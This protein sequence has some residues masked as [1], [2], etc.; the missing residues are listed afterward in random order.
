MET[1]FLVL[2]A[3]NVELLRPLLPDEVQCE[4]E[5]GATSRELL[6]LAHRV[7]RPAPWAHVVLSMGTNDVGTLLPHET[8]IC[9]ATC[10]QLF[11]EADGV[12]P[13]V[14]LITTPDCDA[15]NRSLRLTYGED[16][17]E[18]PVAEVEADAVHLTAGGAIT[19]AERVLARLYP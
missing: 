3:S 2:G 12:P 15:L 8:D 18:F 17:I 1:K 10:V 6:A 9:I 16:V 7:R 14:H 13:R 5:P 4:A 11:A 19:L